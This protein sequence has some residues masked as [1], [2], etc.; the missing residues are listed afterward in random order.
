VTRK[1]TL[2]AAIGFTVFLT[3]ASGAA[4]SLHDSGS[5]RIAFA[6]LHSNEAVRLTTAGPQAKTLIFETNP[7]DYNFCKVTLDTVAADTLFIQQASVLGFT[8]IGCFAFQDGTIVSSE[9]RKIA[10]VTP[11]AP[12]KSRSDK[13]IAVA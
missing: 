1:Q 11:V 7:P 12:F 3:G 4:K 2:V 5:D 10:P 13:R 8:R 6:S 9:F